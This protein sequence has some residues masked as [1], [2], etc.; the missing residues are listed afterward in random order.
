MAGNPDY[1]LEDQIG[2]R[3][4]LA[5]QRH[6]EIFARLMP[7]LTP[8]QFSTLVR[9]GQHGTLSQNHLGRL[10]AMD[11]AT[12]KGVI[13]RLRRRGLV[14]TVP[15]ASDR[16]RLDLSLTEAGRAML[17][18]ALPVAAQIT[19][20]TL[21]PLSAADAARLADLLDRLAGDRP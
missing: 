1:R 5:S 11:A 18:R 14:A 15:S 16:R 3:L 19:A 6:L 10:V 2:F 7:D 13:D 20:E 9:L 21:H 17:D 4:R 8:T 12:V